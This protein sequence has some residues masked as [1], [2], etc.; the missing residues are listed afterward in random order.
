MSGVRAD[1]GNGNFFCVC[2]VEIFVELSLLIG[3][4]GMG[5]SML[6]MVVFLLMV[7]LALLF[8]LLCAGVFGVSRRLRIGSCSSWKK[9]EGAKGKG[10]GRGG[11]G[12]P[13]R[14][15][16]MRL[17]QRMPPAPPPHYY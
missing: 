5:L 11:N 17:A 12:V 1:G 6:S 7:G 14:S 10:R 16:D 8:L 13:E 3:V 9:R 4:F 2:P 15:S